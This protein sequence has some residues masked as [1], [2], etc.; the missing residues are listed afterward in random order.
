MF[1][2]DLGVR[3]EDKVTG[4]KGIITGRA[5]FLT[6]CNQYIVN[7]GVDKDGK[8]MDTNWVDEDR[9]TVTGAGVSPES[10]RGKVKGGPA[11]V[12]IPKG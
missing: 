11:H 9:L 3:V 5:E 10:V 6:G 7:P 8:M 2:H 1:K 12:S 4:F